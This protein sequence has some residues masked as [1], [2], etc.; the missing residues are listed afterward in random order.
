MFYATS[1]YFAIPYYQ[2]QRTVKQSR[3]QAVEKTYTIGAVTHQHF[4]LGRTTVKIQHQPYVTCSKIGTCGVYTNKGINIG[5]YKHTWT[6]KCVLS[7]TN[8]R[9]ICETNHKSSAHTSAYTQ[10]GLIINIIIKWLSTID[11]RLYLI[12]PSMMCTHGIIDRHCYDVN[13]YGNW[14][15]VFYKNY[16]ETLL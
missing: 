2:K 11:N 16:R 5:A 13:H 3:Q 4:Y 14:F 12:A 15:V 1:T 6:W 8:I 10:R 9:L 7:S